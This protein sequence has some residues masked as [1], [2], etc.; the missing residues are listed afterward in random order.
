M[1]AFIYR[2]DLYRERD[3]T[4]EYYRKVRQG[5]WEWVSLKGFPLWKAKRILSQ[6]TNIKHEQDR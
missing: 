6:R 1:S 3:G 2:G 5:K 4:I